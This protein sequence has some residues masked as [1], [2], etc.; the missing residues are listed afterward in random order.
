[1]P[2]VGY[3]DALSVEN[4]LIKSWEHISGLGSLSR[5][6][7]SP[8][9]LALETIVQRRKTGQHRIGSGADSP[10]TERRSGVQ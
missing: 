10:T 9:G 3:P 2:V 1:M 5:A 7:L 8:I 4:F 6:Q